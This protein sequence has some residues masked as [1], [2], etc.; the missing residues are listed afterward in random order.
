MCF[1][2]DD[3]QEEAEWVAEEIG[4][5]VTVEHVPHHEISVLY[6]VNVQSRALEDAFVRRGV[7]YRVLSGSGFYQR[8]EIR[9]VAAYLRLALDDGDQE[10][11]AYLLGG[12]AGIGPR[13]LEFLS[14]RH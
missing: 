6:R 3:E 1:V 8:A 14:R 9:R 11:A 12:V 7:P 2:G 4:R 13:R 5:L 10:A